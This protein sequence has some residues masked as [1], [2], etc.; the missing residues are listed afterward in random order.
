MRAFVP[1][2]GFRGPVQMTG[3]QTQ[4]LVIAAL[5]AA[6]MVAGLSPASLAGFADERLPLHEREI[7]LRL[8]SRAIRVMLFAR[9]L[10][11]LIQACGMDMLRHKGVVYL[12]DNAHRAVFRGA[13]LP[14]GG[15]PGRA[16]GGQRRAKSTLIFVGRNLPEDVFF[17]GLEQCLVQ[18]Q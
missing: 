2:K 3:P 12:E 13:Y 10:M 15:D 17:K 18:P 1:A 7:G 11:G 5:P 4:I 8:A 14:L 6:A 9:R 16:L